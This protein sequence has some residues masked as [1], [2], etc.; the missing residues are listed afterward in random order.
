MAKRG[1]TKSKGGAAGRPLDDSAR[2]VILHGPENYLRTEHLRTLREAIETQRGEVD[3]LHF[4]GGSAAA[5]D[6]LDE[7]R[8]L[9]LMQ[10][11]KIIV[12]DEADE[13]LKRGENRRSIEHYTESPVESVTLVLR[14]GA[15]NPGKLDKMV[16]SVGR[17]VKCEPL[18]PPMA[19]SFCI[20][21]CAKRYG[22]TIDPRAAGLLVERI[23]ASLSRLDTELARL[24]LMT[25][26]AGG[27]IDVDLVTEQ[28]QLSREEKAWEVQN[29]LLT[30]DGA[31]A[32]GKVIELMTISR[33][34]PVPIFYA[35]TDL[36]RK[37]YAARRL[38]DA[39]QNE[40][41][42]CSQLRLW[43]PSVSALLSAARRCTATDLAELMRECLRAV[44]RPRQ[45]LGT[46][47]RAVEQ[48]A[49]RF[50]SVL[51]SGGR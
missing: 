3:V 25:E 33:L 28:I 46:S 14:A 17:V 22:C 41:V 42:V 15:W 39:G 50:L 6:V 30:G 23:G 5:A 7:A 48:L 32:L 4:D 38:F 13:F 37:I 12:V 27:V 11:Y 10:Q 2:V 45:S 29:A 40:R 34:D 36:S 20:Q 8:S 35:M 51:G 16:E 18:E 47:E 43:G 31:T 44:H 19:I 21:R 1:A 49:V 24:S 26:T 9:G